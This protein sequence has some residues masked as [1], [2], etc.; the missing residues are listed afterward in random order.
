MQCHVIEMFNE[1]SSILQRELSETFC[2]KV[3]RRF[4]AKAI[5]NPVCFLH[6]I[7]GMWSVQCV[8]SSTDM[9]FVLDV[10]RVA[11][12]GIPQNVSLEEISQQFADATNIFDFRH[13][14]V[15]RGYV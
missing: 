13:E 7:S 14:H 10:N 12:E 4:Y 15:S 3:M 1:T 8:V 11:L 2:S 6:G 9:S 5:Q